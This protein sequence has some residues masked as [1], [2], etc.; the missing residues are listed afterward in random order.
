MLKLIC[1]TKTYR[2]D[3]FALWLEY[4]SQFGCKICILDNESSVNV[5]ERVSSFANENVSY[6]KIAGFADQWNLFGDIL[7]GKTDLHFDNGDL[8]MFLDDD[9]FLWYDASQY[10][11]LE[12]VLR[13]QYKQL[14]CLLLPEILMSTHHITHNRSKLSP[15]ASYY[16]RN[17]FATQG[18]ACILWNDWTTY[19]YNLKNF[20]VGHVPWM[21]GVRMSDVVGSGVTKTTYGVCDY[22]A[23]VRLYHYHIKSEADWQIKIA[24][25]SAACAAEPNKNGAYDTDI[26]RNKKFG[27]YDTLDFT[28]KLAVEKLLKTS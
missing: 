8:V 25:G 19:S 24:R 2:L 20:E 9:E 18:K 14:S 26:T 17:D 10:S 5:S 28:M 27:N 16:R 15:L 12:C 21:N 13:A 4:H 7:N 3:D 6:S 1:L 23:P 11:S 22:D